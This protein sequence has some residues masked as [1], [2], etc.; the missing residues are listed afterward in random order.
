MI[1]KKNLIA[2]AA[3]T[4][5]CALVAL[6]STTIQGSETYEIHPQVAVPYGY[7]PTMDNSRLIDMVE[8]LMYQDRQMDQQQL[9]RISENIGHLTEMLGSIDAKLTNLSKRMTRIEKAL[10]IKQPARTTRKK[11]GKKNQTR[12]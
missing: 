3:V 11:S 4:A 9:A 8:H 10:K 5:C 6:L 7:T 2:L 1:T 12:Q